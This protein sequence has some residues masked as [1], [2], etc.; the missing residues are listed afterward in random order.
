MN[1]TFEKARILIID[2][3]PGNIKTLSEILDE[4]YITSMAT[5]WQDA[6]EVIASTNVDLILLDVIMPDIDGY[7]ICERLKA[8]AATRDIPVIFVTSQNEEIDETRGLD[9]G[10]VDYIAKPARPA[11]IKARIKNHLELKWQRDM[12]RKEVAEHKK[13]RD[14]LRLAAQVFENTTEAIVVTDHRN[15]IIDVNPAFT[16]LTGF[17]KDEAMGHDPGFAKSGRHDTEFY[18]KLWYQLWKT[19]SWEGEM[20]DR[21][22]NGEIFPKLVS[23]NLVKNEDGEVINCIAVF[24]DASLAKANEEQLQKFAF[25]DSLTG[26]DNR[27]TFYV[28]LQQEISL[29]KRYK[30]N[31]AVICIDLDK[32][33]LINDTYGHAIGDLVLIEVASR[34]QSC[35]RESDSVARMGGDEFCIVLTEVMKP[36]DCTGIIE[37]ILSVLM[38]PIDTT[39]QILQV[40]ASIGVAVG[41][42]D[43]S[44]VETIMKNADV[45]MGQ[46]KNSA[47][48]KYRFFN[49]E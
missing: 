41:L 32:F 18:S 27:T 45:A 26:L 34:I 10:T 14:G 49:P 37:K 21:R 17:H 33:K 2:D 19:G 4:D 11:I 38:E 7:E 15:R 16:I 40:E 35:L 48:I 24:T 8:D 9:L 36:A 43:G 44:D 28:R 39:G 12:L 25:K 30:K 42:D 46:A 29:A 47:Q 1:K 23:V 6:M 22:K 13:A 3:I 5:N 20:W 31:I